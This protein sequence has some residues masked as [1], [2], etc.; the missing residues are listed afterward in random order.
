M[1]YV[2]NDELNYLKTKFPSLHVTMTSRDKSK[3]KRKKHYV[4]EYPEIMKRLNEY[5]NGEIK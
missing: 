1:Q 3:G 2:T 4:D 5:R